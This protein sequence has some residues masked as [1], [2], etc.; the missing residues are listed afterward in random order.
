MEC[1]QENSKQQPAAQEAAQEAEMS[2][3]AEAALTTL[4]LMHYAGFQYAVKSVG[5]RREYR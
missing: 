5:F 4:Y 1:L 2:A 3:L